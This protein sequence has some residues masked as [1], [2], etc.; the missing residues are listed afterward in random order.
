MTAVG[1]PILAE[2]VRNGWLLVPIPQGRKGPVTAK[3]NTRELCIADPEIA[4]WLDGNVG[5]AHSYSGT[6]AID[7]DDVVQCTVWLAER[8]INLTAL[9]DAP[10]ATGITLTE[11]FAMLPT[12]AVSGFY[13]AHPKSHYFG[14]ARVGEDQ[15]VEYAVRRG[16]DLEQARQ[17]LR[18]NLD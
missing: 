9:L 3:W 4:E 17:W 10:D 1:R 2:Y 18:P 5:L 7:V 14:V 6:C 16:V 8:D 13:F 12:A 15:L 11:S